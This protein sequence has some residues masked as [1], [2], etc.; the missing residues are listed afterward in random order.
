MTVVLWILLIG[1]LL[2]TIVDEYTNPANMSVAFCSEN[3]ASYCNTYYKYDE[4]GNCG[5]EA[6]DAVGQADKSARTSMC[7][8]R[9]NGDHL[10]SILTNYGA[11][12]GLVTA[13]CRYIANTWK[14]CR[15]KK[16]ER[17]TQI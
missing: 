5:G 7:G 3:R 16:L 9:S 2:F 1:V 15:R 12:S 4:L 14:G 6:K 10:L 13:L 11:L 8:L 17:T